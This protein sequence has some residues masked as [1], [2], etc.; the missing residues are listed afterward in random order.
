MS[1]VGKSNYTHHPHRNIIMITSCCLFSNDRVHCKIQRKCDRGCK[2]I[3]DGVR[4]I[5]SRWTTTARCTLAWL[6]H[7]IR[8]LNVTVFILRLNYMGYLLQLDDI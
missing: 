8:A 2:I 5:P 6:N 7:N 1:Y 4:G 3:E